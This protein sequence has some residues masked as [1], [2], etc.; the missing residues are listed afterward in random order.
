[1]VPCSTTTSVF[2]LL[3]RMAAVGIT[4]TFCSSLTMIETS[5]VSPEYRPVGEPVTSMTTGKL[6]T[7]ELCVAMTPTEA[8]WPYTGVVEPS[9]VMVAWSPV[10]NSPT[11]VSSTD[12]STTYEPVPVTT[13][14]ALEVEDELEELD[15]LAAVLLAPVNPPVPPK[16]VEEVPPPDVLDEDE[17][18][19]PDA[20]PETCW[21]TVRSSAATV[22]VMVD[23]NV[24]SLSDSWAALSDAWAAVTAD[25]SAVTCAEEVDVELWSAES[26]ALSESSVAWAS[27]T[28][29]ERAVGSTVARAWP[30]V[31]L[32]PTETSTAVTRPDTEKSRSA[33]LAAAMVPVADAVCSIVPYATVT[34]RVLTVDA[35][36]GRVASHA[37]RPPPTTRTTTRPIVTHRRVANL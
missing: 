4:R 33:V 23:V 16:P 1:M 8:T 37:P 21:P 27:S 15:E 36:A 25:S 5:A 2:P 31:T 13:T 30:A 17:V 22:P 7:P 24:A 26:L 20:V 35:A 34:I 18:P 29:A 19:E 10:A 32:W 3:N 14:W 9:G 6:A 11:W 28:W 12:A